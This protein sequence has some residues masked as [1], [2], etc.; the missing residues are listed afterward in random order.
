MNFKNYYATLGISG[1]EGFDKQALKGQYHEAAKRTHPDWHQEDPEA[2]EKFKDVGEAF[3][4]LNDDDRRLKYNEI[5]RD[6]EVRDKSAEGTQTKV[7]IG[8]DSFYRTENLDTLFA[9]AKREID[10]LAAQS[11]VWIDEIARQ[12]GSEIDQVIRESA[13]NMDELFNRYR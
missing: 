2:E 8:F 10:D 9:R 12:S 11:T 13:N 3:F 6:W 5:Y 1:P 7:D 4:V